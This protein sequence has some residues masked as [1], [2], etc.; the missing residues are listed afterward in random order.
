MHPKGYRKKRVNFPHAQMIKVCQELPAW[1]GP[2]TWGQL[3]SHTQSY[4]SHTQSGLKTLKAVSHIPAA[5]SLKKATDRI[6][7]DVCCDD[8]GFAAAPWLQSNHGVVGGWCV[9]A[10][11]IH[12]I[13]MAQETLHI[14]AISSTIHLN[15]VQAIATFLECNATPIFTTK[16]KCERKRRSLYIRTGL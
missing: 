3:V 10:P 9:R 5:D 1:A 12:H 6:L 16:N 11:R 13:S 15:T 14:A 8:S 7:P 2:Y 4:M